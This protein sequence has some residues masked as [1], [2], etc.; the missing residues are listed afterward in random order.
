MPTI[1]TCGPEGKRTSFT[2]HRESS[3]G[4]T[5]EFDSSNFEIPASVID[6]LLTHFKGQRVPGGFS[7]TDPTPGGV[8]EFLQRQGFGLTP[9]HG[10]FLC[11]AL[12][13]ERQVECSLDGNAIMVQFDA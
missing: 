5:V 10:S 2:Y 9:R 8:G 12:H 3:G 6:D 7:M 1:E 13:H 11:A 4:I